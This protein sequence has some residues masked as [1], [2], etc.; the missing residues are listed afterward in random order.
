MPATSDTI[1][2]YTEIYNS[3]YNIQDEEYINELRKSKD[4]VPR[5]DIGHI[6][7][8]E[9]INEYRIPPKKYYLT[10]GTIYRDHLNTSISKRKFE[11]EEDIQV[12]LEEE[13]KMNEENKDM[14]M[15]Y[16]VSEEGYS[17]IEIK[18]N[19]ESLIEENSEDIEWDKEFEDCNISHMEEIYIQRVPIFQQYSRN[20]ENI[21]SCVSNRSDTRFLIYEEAVKDV[22]LEDEKCYL[23]EGHQLEKKE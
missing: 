17:K 7:L 15:E 11:G 19:K 8:E 14:E 5:P 20:N 18:S 13:C 4:L 6:L 21:S 2:P 1:P 10:E 16:I 3:N 12:E 22:V 9:N 23:V